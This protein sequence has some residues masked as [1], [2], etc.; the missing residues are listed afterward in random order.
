MK[1][2]ILIA[3]WTAALGTGA[4]IAQDFRAQA[5]QGS[6]ARWEGSCQRCAMNGRSWSAVDGDCYFPV[7]MT[8]RPDHYEIARWCDGERQSGWLEVLEKPC[9]E[10]AIDFPNDKYVHLSAEDLARH[11]GEQAQIKPVFRRREGPPRFTLALAKPIEPLTGSDDFG[12]CRI[13]NGE[14]KNR[15]TG[16]DYQVTGTVSSVADGTVVLTGDHFFAGQSVYVDHGNGLV[17]MYFHLKE[18]SVEVGQEI[19]RGDALGEIG[20]TGRS[21]GPHLHLGLRWHNQRINPNLLLNDPVQLPQ[22]TAR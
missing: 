14:V 17:S 20:S 18:I 16:S 13:F 11:Y 4:L 12:V 6:V 7:D 1:R 3:L 22:V 8:R 15:H 21:T 2:T 5:E 9:T 10:D 19:S